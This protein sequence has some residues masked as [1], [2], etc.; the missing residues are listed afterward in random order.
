MS[1]RGLAEGKVEVKE[2]KSEEEEE[3]EAALEKKKHF[4]VLFCF[5]NSRLFPKMN[6]SSDGDGDPTAAPDKHPGSPLRLRRRRGGER[7]AEKSAEAAT[8]SASSM[9]L[10]IDARGPIL[11]LFSRALTAALL[12]RGGKDLFYL[13]PAR[14]SDQALVVLIVVFPQNPPQAALAATALLLSCSPS[15][16]H[17]RAASSSSLPPSS[18]SSFFEPVFDPATGLTLPPPSIWNATSAAEMKRP[19]YSSL[20]E[21]ARSWFT[22][23]F[24]FYLKHAFPHDDLKPISCSGS[25]SQGGMALTRI[26]AMTTAL[27]LGEVERL[28]ETVAWASRRG[29][30]GKGGG[31]EGGGGGGGSGGGGDEQE[32]LRFD[33]K[34]GARVHVFELTIRAVGAL[35][36]SHI[37][38]KRGSMLSSPSF[39]NES[40]PSSPPSSPPP[41]PLRFPFYDGSSLL[42]KALD[43]AE[44]L[45]PAFDTPTGIP[46]SWVNLTETGQKP[47][48]PRKEKDRSTCA[49][50]A[51]TLLLEFA[52]LTRES[53]D[54]RFELAAARAARA[55]HSLRS[56]LTG[57]V[58]NTVDVDSGA[59]LRRDS[60]VGAGIDSYYE[61]LLKSYLLTG[62]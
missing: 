41:P 11:N 16:D 48:Q 13:L 34:R 31:G 15:S 37:Y 62:E 51:G 60:G 50:C 45:L 43:L 44:R 30:G 53:G 27:M 6:S 56:P 28:E 18:S 3:E 40:S 25:D 23:T 57:L 19:S 33:D 10:A 36:S 4:S 22:S 49:A 7:A 14:L 61:Y 58:G 24:D 21:E 35:V 42:E 17:S 55:L 20:R 29:G 59:F 54:T 26:D 2:K 46:L 32:L 1:D 47:F 8:R 5:F 12:V 9:P 52:T 39:L 38:L